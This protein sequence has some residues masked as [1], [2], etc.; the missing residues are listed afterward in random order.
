M[1]A[2]SVINHFSI[3][4]STIL[5]PSQSIFMACLDINHLKLPD[6]CIG[7]SALFGQ[8][9]ATFQTSFFKPVE[10]LGQTDGISTSFSFQVLASKITLITSGITSPALVIKTSS[11][12]LISFFANSS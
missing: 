4:K 1:D 12:I 2:K 8:Y 10:Q 9:I 5:S 11:H 3:N 6:I 7:H